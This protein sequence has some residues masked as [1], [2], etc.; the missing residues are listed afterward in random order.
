MK[1]LVVEDDRAIAQAL[2]S[3]LE[4]ESFAVDIAYDGEEGY[5]AAT[6]EEYDLLILDLMLPG[7]NGL[8]VAKKLRG[9]KVQSRILMLTAR[10][11]IRDKV[12]GLNSGADDYLAKPFS[13]EE[14]LAR[15]RAL[16]R[17]PGETLGTTLKA[18][19]LTLDTV[20]KEVRRGKQVIN[21]SAKEYA[22]L[23]Y[24]LRNKGNVLSKSNIMSHVWDFEAD[25]LP[26]T[27]E[28]F[29]NFLRSKIDK[30]FKGPK[31]IKTVRGFGYKIEVG[32]GK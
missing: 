2:K 20:K 19:D 29:M 16:L 10:G 3:G 5:M 30:P 11:Q 21:L 17:R 25:I 8:L 1:I 12:T 28:V 9:E 14:L 13:F 18:N 26:N 15:V 23:E 31:L 6:A 4:Q 22:L 32:Y 27:V 7:M 24:M